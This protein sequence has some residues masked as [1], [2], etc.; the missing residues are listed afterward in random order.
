MPIYTYQ[1]DN[2]GVRF[3]R[4]QRFSDAPLTKCP[5]CRK[6]RLRKLLTSPGIVFKGS[7]WYAT[8][9]RSP[10]GQGNSARSGDKPARESSSQSDKPAKAEKSSA[11]SGEE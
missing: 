4:T 9:H 11:A 6:N 7:G 5:E 10:S 3:E 2:C 1:C 8:D